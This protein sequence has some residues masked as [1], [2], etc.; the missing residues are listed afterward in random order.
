LDFL[1]S[2]R[3]WLLHFDA[4]GDRQFDFLLTGASLISSRQ[5]SL[6]LSLS[7]KYQAADNP[8]FSLITPAQS[9]PTQH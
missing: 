4:V 6:F 8:E 9:A 2:E 1:G 3:Q 7:V 5:K